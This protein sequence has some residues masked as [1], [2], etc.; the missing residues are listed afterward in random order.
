LYNVLFSL[1]CRNNA[2]TRK[3][4]GYQQSMMTDTDTAYYKLLNQRAIIIDYDVLLN[5]LWDV[6]GVN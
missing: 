3:D 6:L 5:Y 4:K 2:G 1:S